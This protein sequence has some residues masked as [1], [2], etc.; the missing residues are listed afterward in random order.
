MMSDKLY[1]GSAKNLKKYLKPKGYSRHISER[2]VLYLTD[3]LEMAVS[4]AIENYINDRFT[5]INV[6]NFKK[7]SWDVFYV[8]KSKNIRMGYVYETHTP[9]DA[10]LVDCLDME[11]NDIVPIENHK[12]PNVIGAFVSKK[13]CAIS[14]KYVIDYDFLKSNAGV[15]VFALKKRKHFEKA[16]QKIEKMAAKTKTTDKKEYEKRMRALNALLDQYTEKQ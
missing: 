13:D 6:Y 11:T 8:L 4:Y 5:S 3:G 14:A 15:K 10:I 7:Q 2:N 16:M 9:D 1:H 12:L